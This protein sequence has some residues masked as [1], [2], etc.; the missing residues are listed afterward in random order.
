MLNRMSLLVKMLGKGFTIFI[1]YVPSM[2]LATIFEFTLS[3]FNVIYFAL[4][5][6][7]HVYSP[8]VSTGYALL[9][10]DIFSC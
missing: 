9:N 5:A 8:S 4:G 7:D 6:L 10:D 2:F 1:K 3:F